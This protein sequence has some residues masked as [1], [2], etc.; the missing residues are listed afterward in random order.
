MNTHKTNACAR[1]FACEM[2]GT[3]HTCPSQNDIETGNVFIYLILDL[4]CC[5]SLSFGWISHRNSDIYWCARAICHPSTRVQV[6]QRLCLVIGWPKKS[7]GLPYL[8]SC[9]QST[10]PCSLNAGTIDQRAGVYASGCASQEHHT[11][12]GR[13]KCQDS[14]V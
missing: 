13:V 3:W 12:V 1:T 8:Y 10:R 14:Q 9:H 5:A 4:Y 2:H 7:T 6:C 11:V